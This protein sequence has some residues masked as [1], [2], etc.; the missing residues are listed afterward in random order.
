MVGGRDAKA[1]GLDA[2]PERPIFNNSASTNVGG[3]GRER[4]MKTVR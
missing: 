1:R 2:G 3:G 4:R